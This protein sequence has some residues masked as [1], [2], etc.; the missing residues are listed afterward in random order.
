MSTA[1]LLEPEPVVLQAG[2]SPASATF[3]HTYPA[4]WSL[5]SVPLVPDDPSPSAVF[6]EAPTPLRL[7]DYVEG[8]VLAAGD[9]G[10]R[11]VA[12][13]RAYWLLLAA[14]LTV[15]A[16]GTPVAAA[17]GHRI[18]LQPGWN[19]IATPWLLASEWS[20]AQVSVRNG[21]STLALGA[22]AAAGWVEG[23][24]HEPDPG[25]AAYQPIPP[26]ASPAALL[27]AW[28]GYELF[29]SITGELIFAPPPPDTV[30]PT[31]DFT[32]LPDG[33]T[34]TAPIEIAGS[35]GDANLVAWRLEY[36][37]AEGGTPVVLGSGHAPVSG[38]VLGTFDPTVLLNGIYDVRLVATDAA[39]TTTTT[40]RSVVVSGE[41]KV[42]NFTVSFVD[43]EVPVAGLPI[44]VTRTY[45]SRDKRRGDFGI[46]WRVELANLKLS[47]NVP[48][49]LDWDGTR[50]GGL[51]PNYCI[52]PA[53]THLVTVTFPDGKV[54]EFDAEAEPRCQQLFPLQET[55][56]VYRARPGTL[57]TLTPLD[58]G[59]VMVLPGGWPGP[60]QL[61][62]W[63]TLETYDPQA[64]VLRL[65]DGRSF[66]VHRTLGLQNITDANGNQ[67]SVGPN[68]IVHSSGKGV[69]FTRDGLGRITAITDPAGH[70]LEYAYDANGDL[71]T[72]TDRDEHVT[73]FTYNSSHGL[74]SIA[75]P[76]GVQPIRNDYDENGR[77]VRHTDARGEVIEYARDVAGRQEV[78]TDR[79]GQVRVLEYDDR[80][81]VVRETDPRGKVTTRTFDARNN[82]LTETNPQGET[83]TWTYDA[84]DNIASV[85]DHR[86]A[87]TSWTYD[88][89]GQVLTTT[90]PLGKVTTNVYDARG[91]LLSTTDPDG[92]VTSATYD[93]AGNPLTRTDALGC[94][95]RHEYDS[96]G[97]LTKQVDGLGSVTTYTYDTNGRRLSETRTR[98]VGSATETLVTTF[99]YDKSGR[100][101]E[102][103][104]PDGT[105]T[106]QEYDAAGQVTASVDAL[107]RRT[108]LL[109]DETGRVTRVTFPDG[110]TEETA[111]DAEGQPLTV[112]DRRGG[113]TT[114]EYDAAGRR[115]KTTHPDGGVETVAYDEAGRI[116][117]TTDARG[118]TTR[119]E[120]DASGNRTKATDALGQVTTWT[121]DLAGNEASRRDPRGNTTTYEYDALGRRVRTV[122]PDG[123][124]RRTEY[125]AADNV[126]AET[127][128]AGRTT[129][130]RYDCNG[131]LVEV[132][133]AA[134]KVTGFGYDELGNRN[135]ITDA[136]GRV[137]RFE[138]DKRGRQTRRILPSGHAETKEYDAAGNLL[139]HTDFGGAA[140]TYEYD[141]ADRVLARHHPDGSTTSFTYT[142]G[143]QRATV[144]D[145]RGLTRYGYDP[146]GR[147][148][149][150][151]YPDGRRL[152]YAYDRHGNRTGLTARAGLSS[153]AASYG[154]D[155]LNRPASVTDPL[156]RAYGIGYDANGNRGALS[157][158]N[159]VTTAYTYDAQNRLTAL[160][161]TRAAL[162]VFASA[163]T[164]GPA[165]N[166]TQVV[167][168]DG[169]T[170]AYG[171]D[172][173]YRLVSESVSGTQPYVKNFTYDAVGNRV[174]QVDSATG[175][176]AYAYDE[177]DRLVTA[178]GASYGWSDNGDLTTKPG[179]DGATM[180]WDFDHRLRRA[181]KADG[182]V[183]THAYDA[184]GNRVRT[185]V[186]PPTGP[187]QATDYLVDPAGPLSHVVLETDGAG[188]ALAYYLRAEDDVLAVVRAGSTRF[189]HADGQGSTRRLTDEAGEITDTYAYSAF[190]ELLDHTGSDPNP[191]R[192]AG[193]ALDPNLG[194]YYNRARWLDTA[195][196]R[197]LSPDPFAGLEH[198]PQSLHKYLYAHA[199]PANRTDP[200]GLFSL[201]GMMAAI[202]IRV[203]LFCLAHPTLLAVMGFVAAML[204]PAEVSNS[205]MGVPGFQGIG[206]AN[207]AK[208]R[209]IQLIKNFQLRGY[210][211]QA[212]SGNGRLSQLLG[213]TFEKL[214]RKTLFPGGRPNPQVGK[215]FADIEWRGFLIEIKSTTK[216]DA[217]SKAQLA[218]LS[219]SGSDFVYVFLQKPG[220]SVIKA[221]EEAGGTVAYIF[222]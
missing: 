102:T 210:V 200:T 34:V 138:Y 115:V 135:R 3:Q 166:R 52:E 182:T 160:A 79:L 134:G 163:Y 198:D 15:Q 133:D 38:G 204:I 152:E 81:N 53:R 9:P 177:R 98:V 27:Q 111:Y 209:A 199:D 71:E 58:G 132:T 130:F 164:L 144:N 196:G 14:P 42:G 82:R 184:D 128:Q 116:V 105:V 149:H 213:D 118:N 112:T 150:L 31:V 216:L 171:Y 187:P 21:T 192:F 173:V 183:V 95:A 74:L 140:A 96:T 32:G 190:G 174:L 64:F 109:R 6:D 167:E 139:R 119:Y 162:T 41:L 62:D 55:T 202:S 193:E 161:T 206:A 10:A 186:T 181:V 93:A 83:T 20:D 73:T 29:S 131:Q 19:A 121:Y 154:Y 197:F 170:R 113:V 157:F 78:V 221:I 147:L 40:T 63:S 146:R 189:L 212:L 106:A 4:G 176:I 2:P 94:T 28:R 59:S 108:T 11:T 217:R 35:V 68:G 142:A 191:Y 126:L 215:R 76:R 165:G 180:T 175:S 169:T 1:A 201:G 220:A 25:G 72:V 23:T 86:G 60:L 141:A 124:D 123:T 46:G 159:G 117:A 88:A 222:D 70:A 44:R 48:A 57:S 207:Q 30:P 101:L 16:T 203:T 91:N 172:P 104:A 122:F 143:G 51:I 205:L 7:Y 151:T 89:L 50:S 87:K 194:F 85:T 153:F 54:H 5:V 107:S 218:E 67:L 26:N 148:L 13:G 12:P 97:N 211:K 158:P 90:S 49:G 92:K 56:V 17:G 47:R 75:D 33:A 127:D 129:R 136:N 185:E 110:S 45:D 125:D 39:G 137:T 214:A 114:Y 22:A 84:R 188:T 168:H 120:Y 99:A 24:L 43:L 36:V 37:P 80:G 8:H 219:K 155:A 77:L 65:P 69:A 103:T 178:G 61:V 195:S 66:A 156:G 100:L 179:A 18:A 145:A 208:F